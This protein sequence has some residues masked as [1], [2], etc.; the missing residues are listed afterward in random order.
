MTNVSTGDN[1]TSQDRQASS[2]TGL[3]E[4][5]QTVPQSSIGE[6]DPAFLLKLLIVSF[7]GMPIGAVDELAG[8]R[9]VSQGHSL[10]AFIWCRVGSSEVRQSLARYSFS[11][12]SA[13]RLDF[14]LCTMRSFRYILDNE[15]QRVSVRARC[16]KQ[17]TGK[18]LRCHT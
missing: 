15:E 6:S 16:H 13:S 10:I 9:H 3:A 12:K 17:I 7:A 5:D 4:S 14:H 2:A 11:A 1:Q 18:V 8:G